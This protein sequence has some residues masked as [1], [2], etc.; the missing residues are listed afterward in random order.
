MEK[1]WE[2]ADIQG[3][4]QGDY[5]DTNGNYW[6]S[7]AFVGHGEPVKVVTP[8]VSKW[9]VGNTYYGEITEEKDRRG[10]T[11]YRFRRRERPETPKELDKSTQ[12]F[13]GRDE[14]VISAKWAISTAVEIALAIDAPTIT[15]GAVKAQAKQLMQ[16]IDEVK[17]SVYEG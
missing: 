2:L 8:D 10:N 11:Y 12:G 7:A 16:M 5:R 14:A 6:C 15:M 13:K 3:G 4:R 1:E 9:E 17:E